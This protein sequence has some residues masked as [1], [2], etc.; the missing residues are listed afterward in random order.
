MKVRL[1]AAALAAVLL[2]AAPAVPFAKERRKERSREPAPAAQDA[3]SSTDARLE[4]LEKKVADLERRLRALEARQRAAAPDPAR[5]QEARR[6]YQEADQA[7]QAGDVE[8]A[9]ARI[10]RLNREYGGTAAQRQAARLNQMLSVLGRPAP[11]ELGIEKWFQGRELVQWPSKGTTLLIFWEQW[12]PHCRREVPKIEQTWERYKDRG[13]QVIG[14]TKITR[15]ATEEKVQQFIADNHLTYPIA[16][17]N[18]EMSRAFNVSS[19]PAAAVVKDGKIVW[20]G[21]PAR[22]TPELLEKWL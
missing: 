7:L 1:S 19:I 18:G 16:K 21:H 6:L 22:L 11:K 20:R 4:A 9:R 13:L 15:S 5:E 8:T 17:E 2:L 12:C 14:L 3:G 10:Q